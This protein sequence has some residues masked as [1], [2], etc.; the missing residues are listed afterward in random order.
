MN[1]FNKIE[2]EKY[3]I[4]MEKMSELSGLTAERVKLIEDAYI[5]LLGRGVPADRLT[6]NADSERMFAVADRVKADQVATV[7]SI[8]G[9]LLS[10]DVNV[11]IRSSRSENAAVGRSQLFVAEL[12]RDSELGGSISVIGMGKAPLSAIVSAIDVMRHIIG[13]M[14]SLFPLGDC[15]PASEPQR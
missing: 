5:D 6:A 7:Q 4:S 8:I 2:R 1:R 14:S 13:S 15:I 11:A 9:R 3:G 12:S 10:I